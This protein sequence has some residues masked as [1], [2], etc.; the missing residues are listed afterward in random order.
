[1]GRG[2]RYGHWCGTGDPPDKVRWSA[3]HWS[4]GVIVRR[5]EAAARRRVT[6]ALGSGGQSLRGKA[7]AALEGCGGGE[8]QNN[9]IGK[10]LEGGAH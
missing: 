10:L 5:L 1:V 9:L 6:V 3:A 8:G 4:G 2:K 7:P